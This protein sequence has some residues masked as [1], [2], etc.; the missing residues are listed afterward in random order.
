MLAFDYSDPTSLGLVVS[1]ICKF[2]FDNSPCEGGIPMKRWLLPFLV[3]GM[4]AVAWHIASRDDS[5]AGWW[6]GETSQG[7][8]IE[9]FI[10]T[11]DGHRVIDKWA[12]SL[13][14]ACEKSRRIGSVS[15]FSSVPFQI[16]DGQFDEH[17]MAG[18]AVWIDWN[19]AFK[20]RDH[21]QGQFGTVWAGLTGREL[22]RLG[23]EKCIAAD[24]SWSAQPGH[25]EKRLPS[26]PRELEIII[27]E[28]V[29]K[30]VQMT[31][32]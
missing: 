29:R 18:L 20:S 14:V 31:V 5:P 22:K 10:G 23:L 32:H 13:E 9:F 30:G 11:I 8:P 16:H 12:I 2:A 3:A 21:A 7:L 28:D 19:G 15:M 17:R 1:T 24:L 6:R 4:L 25:G 26:R 27:N